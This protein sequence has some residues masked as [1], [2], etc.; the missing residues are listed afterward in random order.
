MLQTHRIS[1]YHIV[2]DIPMTSFTGFYPLVSTAPWKD[3]LSTHP[4]QRQFLGSDPWCFRPRRRSR[5]PALRRS[6][7]T[8]MNPWWFHGESMVNPCDASVKF[9]TPVV[10]GCV[11]FVFPKNS[12]IAKNFHFQRSF[13]SDSFP[14]TIFAEWCRGDRCMGGSWSYLIMSQASSW[15]DPTHWSINQ[16]IHPSIHLSIIKNPSSINQSINHH[17]SIHHPWIHELIDSPGTAMGWSPWQDGNLTTQRSGDAQLAMAVSGV[18]S[19]LEA[20]VNSGPAEVGSR[21]GEVSMSAIWICTYTSYIHHI[22]L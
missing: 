22:W 20:S 21:V 1:I 2:Y 15:V 6:G 12:A 9:E 17:P 18:I 16:S 4:E 13:E 10:T 11:V 8:Q 14:A 3:S 19:V 5:V 7:L